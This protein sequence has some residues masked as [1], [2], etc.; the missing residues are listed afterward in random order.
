MYLCNN[1]YDSLLHSTRLSYDSSFHN[2]PFYFVSIY[3][4]SISKRRKIKHD[5]FC[6]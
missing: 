6:K 5:I 4:V 1:R 2:M 3:L